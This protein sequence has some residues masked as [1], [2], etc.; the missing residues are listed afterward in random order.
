[1][2]Q[3][4][5]VERLSKRVLL[6]VVVV[7]MVAFGIAMG[8]RLAAA[9]DATPAGAT[10]STDAC[11]VPPA[12]TP[13][14]EGATPAAMETD[15]QASPAAE[16]VPTPAGS[17]ASDGMIATVRTLAECVNAGDYAAAAALL[18]DNFIET[19]L[20]V[21]GAD[22][23]AGALE[24]AGRMRIRIFQTPEQYDDGTASVLVVY[25]GFLSPTDGPVAER[26]F[27]VQVGGVY[28]VDRIEPA[29]LPPGFS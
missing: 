27:F 3:P 2:R 5:V 16:I 6:A 21:S 12:G 28:K 22:E 23:A 11:V 9:Q 19:V 4:N 13:D 26:W 24:G 1:M 8:P 10:P 25:E 17:D 20:G 29:E 7:A 15:A 18:T 14:A